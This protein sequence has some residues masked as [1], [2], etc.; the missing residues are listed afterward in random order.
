MPLKKYGV[1]KG[2]VID[3]KLGAGN[4]SH[5]QVLINTNEYKHR[6][7]INVKSKLNPS[8][9]LY[10]VDDNFDHPIT[11]ELLKLDY[12]FNELERKPGGLALDYVRGNLFDTTQMKPYLTIFQIP[13]TI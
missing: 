6:I 11:Q 13:T 9:L 12:G 10:F 5:Y 1:L 2:K 8:E 4:N 7:A 3:Q